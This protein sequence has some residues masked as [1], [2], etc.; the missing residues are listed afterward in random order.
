M[1]GKRGPQG[2]ALKKAG[3]LKRKAESFYKMEEYP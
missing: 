3:S 1:S 2:N